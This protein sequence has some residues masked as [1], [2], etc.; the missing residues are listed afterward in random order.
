MC[1][2]GKKFRGTVEKFRGFLGKKSSSAVFS[3]AVPR[4]VFGGRQAATENF[5]IFD[6]VISDFLKDFEH[7]C[8]VLKTFPE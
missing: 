1:H 7:L 2:L 5:G 4:F 6:S 8:I 3:S